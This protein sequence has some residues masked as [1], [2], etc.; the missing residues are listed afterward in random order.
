MYTNM[1]NIYEIYMN[2]EFKA[3]NMFIYSHCNWDE[4]PV[5]PTVNE[6]YFRSFRSKM[7]KNDEV[8]HF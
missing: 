1:Q 4:D 7:I 3:Q 2:I 8:Q 6:H 5:T